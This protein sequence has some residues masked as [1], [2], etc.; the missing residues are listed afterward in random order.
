VPVQ[1]LDGILTVSTW[2]ARS[3]LISATIDASVVVDPGPPGR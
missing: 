3:A 2:H 1:E